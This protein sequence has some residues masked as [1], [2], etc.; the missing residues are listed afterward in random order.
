MFIFLATGI[1]Y[2]FEIERN[3][4]IE[5]TNT[6][7]YVTTGYIH[8]ALKNDITITANILLDSSP[9]FPDKRGISFSY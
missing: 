4:F 2:E 7:C 6:I 5:K 3:S 9:T 8:T 1:L